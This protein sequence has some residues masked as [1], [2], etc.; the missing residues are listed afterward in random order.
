[1]VNI[2]G[3]TLNI[4]GNSVLNDVSGSTIS[5]DGFK[6]GSKTLGQLEF[7]NLDGQ[8]QAIKSTD[9]PSFIQIISTATSGTAPFTITSPTKVVNLNAD[10]LDSQH[11][12]TGIIVGTTDTQTLTNKTLDNVNLSGTTELYGDFNANNNDLTNLNKLDGFELNG[13]MNLGLYGIKQVYG[14]QISGAESGAQDMHPAT[15]DT[16]HVGTQSP[17]PRGFWVR[18]LKAWVV[19]DNGYIYQYTLENAGNIAKGSYDGISFNT[20]LTNPTGLIFRPNGMSLYVSDNTDKKVMQIDM[21]TA[22]DLNTASASGSY[23]HGFTMKGLTFNDDGSLFYMANTAGD[24]MVYVYDLSTPY[25]IDSATYSYQYDY[26][27]DITNAQGIQ[28]SSDGHRFLA[29]ESWDDKIMYF[30]CGTPYDLSTVLATGILFI[31]ESWGDGNGALGQFSQYGTNYY[32]IGDG[33]Y[34]K[35]YRINFTILG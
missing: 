28:W 23:S 18:G 11:A 9:T 7:D 22:W 20:S 25:K 14:W 21:S 24:E 29:G 3:S 16:L 10:L 12:P 34:A 17:I 6:I 35:Q 30:D 32:T 4:S 26:H 2:S 31:N 33:D 13:E 19:D 8:D 27:L 1:M 15:S 5:A